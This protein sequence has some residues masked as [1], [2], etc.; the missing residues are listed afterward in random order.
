MIVS[1]DLP[2]QSSGN[3]DEIGVDEE[4]AI[5]GEEEAEAVLPPHLTDEDLVEI[6][7]IMPDWRPVGRHGDADYQDYYHFGVYSFD[8]K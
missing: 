4:Y 3:E 6:R 5:A 8:P 1:D 2:E 7:R